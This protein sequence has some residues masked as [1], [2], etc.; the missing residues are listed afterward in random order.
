MNDDVMENTQS[1]LTA[2][3]QAA[4]VDRQEQEREKGTIVAVLSN[5]RENTKRNL[6][7]AGSSRKLELVIHRIEL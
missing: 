1:D 3:L 6:R 2:L 4:F 7:V 5:T